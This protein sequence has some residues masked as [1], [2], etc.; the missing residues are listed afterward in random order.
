M[1]ESKTL[2]II[3]NANGSV[4]GKLSYGYRKLTSDKQ[5]DAPCAACDLTP[6]GLSL[7]ETPA[8]QEAK[9]KIQD[10]LGLQVVQ[11][12]LDER[13]PEVSRDHCSWRE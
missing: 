5:G 7:S 10:L 6:G 2:Y 3:Y 12:H 4:F 11:L 13:T 1:N 8:W 9:K